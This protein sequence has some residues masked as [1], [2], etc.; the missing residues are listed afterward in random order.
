MYN[1]NFLEN[2]ELIEVFDD[3]W[4]GQGDNEKTTTIALTN[5]RLLFLDYDPEDIYDNLRI[6]EG[7]HYNRYKEIYY[8]IKLKDIQNIDKQ[9]TYTI[10]LKNGT[11]FEIDNN[12]LFN[13]IDKELYEKKS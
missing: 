11:S 10:T 2:E 4:V 13:L 8:S 1:F 3:I 12:D 6:A 5:Q 9:E 7:I